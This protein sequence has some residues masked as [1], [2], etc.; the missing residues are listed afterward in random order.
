MRKIRN[1]YS[2]SYIDFYKRNDVFFEII[3]KF[4]DCSRV[5]DLYFNKRSRY[6][7]EWNWRGWGTIAETSLPRFR[8]LNRFIFVKQESNKWKELCEQNINQSKRSFMADQAEFCKPQMAWSKR[9]ARNRTGQ[10]FSTLP[11]VRI[12]LFFNYRIECNDDRPKMKSKKYFY[13]ETI[14]TGWERRWNSAYL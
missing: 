4:L 11:R 13:Y 2:L 5:N 10:S 3:I 7:I 14:A 9:E 12:E 8:Q 6:R 1:S